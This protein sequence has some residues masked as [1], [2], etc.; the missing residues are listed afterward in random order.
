MRRTGIDAAMM[1][2]AD[3]AA[4]LNHVSVVGT[5]TAPRENTYHSIK[6]ADTSVPCERL[7][8]MSVL[9]LTGKV[10]RC[11]CRDH[12]R[13]GN[14]R[15]AGAAIVSSYAAGMWCGT[16]KMPMLMARATPTFSLRFICSLQM[17]FHGRRARTKSMTAE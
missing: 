10:R 1:V 4:L 6:G 16:H 7:E 2:T 15:S 11:K 9:E 5:K 14:G 12:N 8:L 13:F 17:T 3:S